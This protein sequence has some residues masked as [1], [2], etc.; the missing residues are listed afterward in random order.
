MHGAGT[1]LEI[2]SST[3]KRL[4][5]LQNWF[6]CLIWQIGQGAP[7]AALLWDS[8]LLDMKIRIWAE[9]VLIVFHIR[10]L[11]KE[12][13]ANR[14][15]MKQFEEN[16]PGLASETKQICQELNIEDCNLT[17][18][19]KREYKIILTKGCHIKN[20]Q[21]LRATASEVKCNRIRQEPYGKKKPTQS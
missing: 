10:S 17:L 6:V 13:L 12:S 15:Y 18:L 1:W 19:N 3:E 11:D 2:D 4:N 9:K 14:V 21:I 20:E 5:R 16:W 7:L 8:Q